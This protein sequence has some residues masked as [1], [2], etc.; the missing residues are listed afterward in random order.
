MIFQNSLGVYIAEDYVA[1]THTKMRYHKIE[2]VDHS[3]HVIDSDL[4]YE[5]RVKMAVNVVQPFVEQKRLESVDAYFCVESEKSLVRTIEFPVSVRENLRNTLSYEIEK[6][7]PFSHQDIYFDFEVIGEDKNLGKLDVLIVVV[8]K[9]VIQPFITYGAQLG[10]GITG[11]EIK[12]TALSNMASV[13]NSLGKERKILLCQGLGSGE[14]INI[15]NGFVRDYRKLPAGTEEQGIQKYILNKYDNRPDT[16]T[17]I[18]NALD[19]GIVGTLPDDIIRKIKSGSSNVNVHKLHFGGISIP[20]DRLIPSIGT[21]LKGLTKVPTD[22]NLMPEKHRKKPKKAQLYLMLVLVFICVVS[23]IVWAASH[24]V[25]KQ[26]VI[27]KLDQEI[28]RLDEKAHEIDV[29]QTEIQA[30]EGRIKELNSAVSSRTAASDI[31]LEM[32]EKIPETA[33]INYLQISEKNI[34]IEGYSSEASSDLI[35][36]LEESDMFKNVVYLSSI[37][38]DKEGRERFKIGLK[39]E[40]K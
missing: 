26:N 2:L 24:F 5:N 38:K 40:K 17:E 19:I 6:Y 18:T 8:R 13:S 28:S 35:S 7:V 31:L 21:A 1:I 27:E 4:D 20:D 25:N 29:F 16:N 3:I 23:G 14:L 36:V 9:E 22:I 37:T 11:I 33:W 34:K 12:A 15:Q 30:L 39:V 10:A 32:T